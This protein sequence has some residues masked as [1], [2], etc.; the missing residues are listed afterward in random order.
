VS[1]VE[2]V[3]ESFWVVQVATTDGSARF[4]AKRQD[5]SNGYGAKRGDWE[6]R[7]ETTHAD[8]WATDVEA[9]AAARAFLKSARATNKGLKH[10][11]VVKVEKVERLTTWNDVF[12]KNASIVEL[13]AAVPVTP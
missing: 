13:V 4:I 1:A 6:V 2:K 7:H 3:A 11:R 5:R 9:K 8:R 10:V 12:T